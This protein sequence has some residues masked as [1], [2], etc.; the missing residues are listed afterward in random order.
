MYYTRSL[1]IQLA[2]AIDVTGDGSQ[3]TTWPSCQAALADILRDLSQNESYH[4]SAG[5][6][7][8]RLEGFNNITLTRNPDYFFTQR[9]VVRSVR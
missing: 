3:Q 4:T 5:N 9:E 6:I 1:I 7:P 8:R 2:L